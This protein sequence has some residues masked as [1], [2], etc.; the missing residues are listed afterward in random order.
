[1]QTLILLLLLAVPLSAH[2]GAVA[3]AVPVEGIVVDG[4]L[5]DWPEGC[6]TDSIAVFLFHLTSGLTT[7][8]V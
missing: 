1:M 2:N 6:C 3:I 5:S 4:D 8:V 7:Y